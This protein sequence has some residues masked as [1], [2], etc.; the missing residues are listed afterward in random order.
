M[1]SFK[2]K[3][4]SYMI[5]CKNEHLLLN[6]SWFPNLSNRYK[7]VSAF[8][9]GVFA[10]P[11]IV[12]KVVPGVAEGVGLPKY[13]SEDDILSYSFDQWKKVPGMIHHKVNEFTTPKT[14]GPTIKDLITERMKEFKR[15]ELITETLKE[16]DR[17]QSKLVT[18]QY[19][20]MLKELITEKREMKIGE[21]KFN[22]GITALVT[23]VVQVIVAT[24]IAHYVRKGVIKAEN[25]MNNNNKNQTQRMIDAHRP[26]E[27]AYKQKMKDK[28]QGFFMNPNNS[29]NI[30]IF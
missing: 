24:V 22:F 1:S 7:R 19:N 20:E 8:I 15:I 25:A 16:A 27:K 18:E 13:K 11:G 17:M 3:R 21:N 29:M 28:S 23:W 9:S 5:G 10:A 14:E 6:N 12:A 4:G 30:G 2:L 26:N